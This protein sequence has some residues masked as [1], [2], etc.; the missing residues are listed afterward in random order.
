MVVVVVLLLVDGSCG[1]S[2]CSS[3]G[4]VRL[5]DASSLFS[6]PIAPIP[7][8]LTLFVLFL[9]TTRPARSGTMTSVL[10]KGYLIFFSY[11]IRMCQP[12]GTPKHAAETT[13]IIRQ[14]N[15]IQNQRRRRRRRQRPK[16]LERENEWRQGK[17]NNNRTATKPNQTGGRPN[18]LTAAKWYQC[19]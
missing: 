7:V 16:N 13:R 8:F 2:S 10:I 3:C 18:F 9:F 17:N 1:D 4:P 19:K 12:M 5:V 15:T 14:D 11:A 6:S